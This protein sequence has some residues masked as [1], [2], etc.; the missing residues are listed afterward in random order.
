MYSTEIISVCVCG[1]VVGVFILTIVLLG[2]LS[3]TEDAVPPSSS[4]MA[5]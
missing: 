5:Q 4:T 3:G 2:V 1:V